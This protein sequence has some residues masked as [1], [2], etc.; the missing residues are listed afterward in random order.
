MAQ[1]SEV[2]AQLKAAGTAQNGR[3]YSR[4]GAAEPMFGVSYAALGKT[5]EVVPYVA[6]TLVHRTR[7]SG[8]VQRL[9]G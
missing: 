3:I 7:R 8:A 9:S 1:L 6:R 2:M 5:P 4:H